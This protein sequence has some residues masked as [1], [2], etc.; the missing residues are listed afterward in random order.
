MT[1]HLTV[2]T[3][4]KAY[5]PAP[6]I[7]PNEAER[8]QALYRLAILE[9]PPDPTFDRITRLAA[10]IFGT[11]TSFVS[12]I[13]ESRQWFKSA[14]GSPLTQTPRDHAF[15][16]YTILQDD[17]LVVADAAK[18]PRF[19]HHP[20]VLED[21][22]IRFYAGAPI[23]T[24]QG[25]NIGSL[26]VVDTKPHSPLSPEQQ[27][28]LSTLANLARDAAEQHHAGLEQQKHEAEVRSRYASVARA[29]LDGLW[30]WDIRSGAVLFSQRWQHALGLPDSDLTAGI[31]HWFDR[32]HPE[33]DALVQADLQRHLEGN[34]PRFSRQ[35]RLLHGDGSWRWFLARGVVQRSRTGRPIRMTGSLI[36]VSPEK[37]TDPL[38][39]LP[40]R[41]QLDQRLNQLIHRSETEQRWSF[42][43][44]SVDID[45]MKRVNDRYGKQV[46]D[47]LL[48]GLALRL[49]DVVAQTRNN[50]QSLVARMAENE[51]EFVLLIDGVQSDAQSH[52]IAQRIETA[53]AVPIDCGQEQLL[54]SVSI[55]IATAGP[56]RPDPE[57]YLQKAGLAMYRA[58]SGGRSASIL[59][60]DGMQDETIAR[61]ELE[62]ALR[63][64]VALDQLRIDYQPQIDLHTG[65]LI[66][67]EALVRWQHP[68]LGLLR[69]ADFISLA[70]E[71]GIIS[72]IDLWVLER[73]CRQLED[74]RHLPGAGALKMSVNFS[75]Q[76]LP[77]RG[78]KQ[79]VERLLK[80]H[81]L[82]PDAL[83]LEL[84]ESVLDEDVQARIGLMEEL[85]SVG[86]GL[87]MDDFGSGYSSFKQLYEL[88][89]D[90]LKI[91]R[92][93]MDKIIEDAKARKIVEGI[94][95]LTHLIGLKVV[96]EGVEDS[97][98]ADLLRHMG[99]D[100]GQGFLYDAPLDAA[101]FE[102][103]YLLC[104]TLRPQSS[105]EGPY[106]A[107]IPFPLP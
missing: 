75:A 81:N 68:R 4:G 107:A 56:D 18:D 50:T 8:L 12:F 63:Q 5:S 86:V 34:T 96:A 38:T 92:S 89:F 17:V 69:P 73:A 66:G 15:C 53:L 67:C 84:T 93:F 11:P 43:V 16:A 94:M 74:W 10:A 2:P 99:C 32:I 39:G 59:F 64:A 13:D 24:L 21:P 47:S 27:T 80:A 61:M 23:V 77:H 3:I 35:H 49:C 87:H 72:G 6:P 83:C 28:I 37:T 14:H 88:P 90:T 78:L 31:S 102:Q 40:G 52:A 71:I 51:D 9:T 22:G 106:S 7:P 85:C 54:A 58:K 60:D 105:R 104:Q 25:Q 57:A 76:H 65:T 33:D 79:S 46:G 95:N 19:Q 98:Q 36:D 101:T 20:A 29:T 42:A 103:R 41:T 62:Q 26:C 48:R 55:G 97:Q 45:R 1:V 91:D 70:E 100:Y 30:D 44:L 82:P